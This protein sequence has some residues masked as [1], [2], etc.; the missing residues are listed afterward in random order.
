MSSGASGEAPSGC[1][2]SSPRAA[3]RVSTTCTKGSMATSQSRLRKWRPSG[4]RSTATSPSSRADRRAASPQAP[5][6][7][8]PFAHLSPTNFPSTKTFANY[9]KYKI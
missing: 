3:K 8:Q 6:A 2:M 9:I 5:T 1:G 4:E 7:G